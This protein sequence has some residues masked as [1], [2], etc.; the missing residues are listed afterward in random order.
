MGLEKFGLVSFTSETKTADFFKF[1]EEGKMMTT[2]CRRCGKVYFPPRM[3]CSVC[4]ASEMEWIKIGEIAK[5][6]AFSTVMYGPAGFE[7]SV[8]YTIAV[9]RFSS[10]VQVFGMI[11]KSIPIDNVKVGMNLKICPIKLP[12]DRVSYEFVQS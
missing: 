5:L 11:S 12:P 9:I 7:D 2:K 3:D 8:P 1:L 6:I 10:G 4:N